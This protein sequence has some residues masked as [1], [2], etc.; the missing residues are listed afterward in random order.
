MEEQLLKDVL[1]RGNVT[2]FRFQLA[3]GIMKHVSLN[4]AQCTHTD[5]VLIMLKDNMDR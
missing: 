5:Q 1:I 4:N 3:L 2:S